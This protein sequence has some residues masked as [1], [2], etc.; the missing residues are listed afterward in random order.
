MHP[1]VGTR[2]VDGHG[3]KEDEGEGED[4]DEEVAADV[5]EVEVIL[6]ASGPAAAP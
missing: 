1:R 5:E 6:E 4:E 2:R 3:S